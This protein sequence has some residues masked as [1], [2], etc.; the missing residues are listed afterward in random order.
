M[1]EVIADTTRAL[2]GVSAGYARRGVVVDVVSHLKL[3][4]AAPRDVLTT[5]RRGRC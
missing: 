3:L 1:I 5:S 2:S 4:L